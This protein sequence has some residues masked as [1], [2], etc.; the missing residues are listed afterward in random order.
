MASD[1][2]A[3]ALKSLLA[4]YRKGRAKK[5]KPHHQAPALTIA[6]MAPGGDEEDEDEHGPR[7]GG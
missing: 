7:K 6:V 5:V 3:E 2:K 4:E 1:V